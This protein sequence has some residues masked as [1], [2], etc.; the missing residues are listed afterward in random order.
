MFGMK[1]DNGRKEENS[2]KCDWNIFKWPFY[3]NN[4]ILNQNVNKI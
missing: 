1:K 3:V 2:K 4:V